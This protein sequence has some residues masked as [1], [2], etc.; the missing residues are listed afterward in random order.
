MSFSSQ[1]TGMQKYIHVSYQLILY[2][3]GGKNSNRQLQITAIS[4]N[5]SATIINVSRLNFHVKAQFAKVSKDAKTR[6]M[7]LIQVKQNISRIFNMNIN[8][9]PNTK[10]INSRQNS[11]KNH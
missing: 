4:P 6:Y 7:L 3:K 10:T 9:A 2:I 8:D 1:E 5:I 11:R